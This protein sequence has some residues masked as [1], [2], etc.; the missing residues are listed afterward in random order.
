VGWPLYLLGQLCVV[1]GF[2]A[3]WRLARAMVGPWQALASV[4]AL[5]GVYYYNLSAINFNPNVLLI[6]LWAWSALTFYRAVRE[7]T[8]KRWLM[9]GVCFGLA[10]LAKY[11]SALLG[12]TLL[13]L[14]IGTVE[15][16]RSAATPGPYLALLAAAAVMSPNL[17]SLARHDF[18]PLRY[19]LYNLELARNPE[20]T[21]ATVHEGGWRAALLFLAEQIGALLPMLLA[22]AAWFVWRAPA[23]P[24]ER[25]DRRLLLGLSIGPLFLVLVFAIASDAHLIARWATPFFN[26]AGLALVATL[27][28]ALD[29]RR[30]AALLIA[31]AALHAL[32]IVGM[33][34]TVV[35]RPAAQHEAPFVAFPGPE[36]ASRLTDD[37]HRRYG[38]P[39]EYVAGDRHLLSAIAAFSTDRPVPYYDWNRD[40]SR[41]VD[42]ER[43]RHRGVLLVHQLDKQTEAGLTKAEVDVRVLNTVRGRFPALRNERV[44]TFPVPINAAVPPVRVWTAYLPPE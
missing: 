20:V 32:A 1:L 18:E 12:V 4:L 41:W 24:P 38:G 35:V 40:L 30:S 39:L 16:R 22:C 33:V 10:G 43:L 31:V 25:F 5:E 21:I 3:V 28:P 14:L 26:V 8:A 17:I 7:R 19:A 13:A 2:V 36:I 15:G 42:R 11:E 6:P 29:R 44:E 9:A 37:W 23:R 27:Q 34:W